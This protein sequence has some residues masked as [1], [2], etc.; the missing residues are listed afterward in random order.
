MVEVYIAGMN[1]ALKLART[2]NPSFRH[3]SYHHSASDGTARS[4]EQENE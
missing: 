2:E 3:L 4:R 1:E